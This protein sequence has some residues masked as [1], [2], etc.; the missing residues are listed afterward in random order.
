[1]QSLLR[2]SARRVN[3]VQPAVSERERIHVRHPRDGSS[4]REAARKGS[5]RRGV[6]A[7]TVV[8]TLMLSPSAFAQGGP[9]PGSATGVSETSAGVPGAP[10][11]VPAATAAAGREPGTPNGAAGAM[12]PAAQGAVTPR[13][14]DPDVMAVVERM[15]QGGGSPPVITR[16]LS[17]RVPFGYEKP[18]LTCQPLRVNL[19]RLEPGESVLSTITGDSESW[20]IHLTR[21]GPGGVTP[22]IVVKPLTEEHVRT[23]LFVTTDKRVYEVILE[24]KPAR[25]GQGNRETTASNMLEFYYPDDVV[26]TWEAQSRY[27][28][29]A[30]QTEQHYAT[31]AP[32][33]GLAPSIP[34]EN[35][36]FTY[37][38]ERDRGFPWEP[39]SVFDDGAHV[40]VKLPR[41]ARHEAGAALFVKGLNGENTMLEYAVREGMI[42][43]DRVFRE[44]Q[45]VYSEPSGRGKAK[46][47]TLTIRNEA[48]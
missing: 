24:S 26:R 6:A 11:G 29:Q 31:T 14:G 35:M 28:Q 42:I 38:W 41:S 1:M 5:F 23:N 25:A 16:G 39:E 27:E 33:V 4:H 45:F 36:A 32:V 8:V 18:T 34:L 17:E 44:A 46:K 19:I 2:H 20:S 3:P 12:P 13:G 47:Y 7:L 15:R 37:E 10:S 30:V 22:L 48:D 40:Y 21:S 9:A 43:T